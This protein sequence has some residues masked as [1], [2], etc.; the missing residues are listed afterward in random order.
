MKR[1][2][3]TESAIIQPKPKFNNPNAFKSLKQLNELSYKTTIDE[4]QKM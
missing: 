2:S 3:R 1:T 4:H